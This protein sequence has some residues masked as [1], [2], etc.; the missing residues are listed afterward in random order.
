MLS[1][2]A[3]SLYWMSRFLERAENTAR[4][5]D[6]HLN[7]VLELTP[8]VGNSRYLDVLRSL[9]I[10]L[11]DASPPSPTELTLDPDRLESISSCIGMARENA[12][13]IREQISSEMFEQ[14]NRLYLFIR[15]RPTQDRFAIEPHSVFRKVKDGSHLF[16][17]ISDSTM[18]HGQGWLW[19]QTGRYLERCSFLTGVLLHHLHPATGDPQH[20][21]E[22]LGI[23]KSCTAWE[24]YCKVHG[25]ELSD[26]TVAEFLVFSGEFPHSLHYCV[27]KLATG[28]NMLAQLTGM[29]ARNEL[30]TRVG[31]VQARL[32]YTPIE[33]LSNGALAPFLSKVEQELQSAHQRLFEIYL[34]HSFIRT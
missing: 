24:A 11:S 7:L 21:T 33:E 25:A 13:Q 10:P 4:A 17:G 8:E 34:S 30:E 6:V 23:L 2:V 3:D 29:T 27:R 12:R 14:I 18:S 31:R 26:T 28:L 5:L 19:I 32:R 20:Y 22:L 15:S 1:R 16:Q 9:H